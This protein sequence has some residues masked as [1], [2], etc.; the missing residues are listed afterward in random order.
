MV[1]GIDSISVVT[2]E[3][4]ELT[5]PIVFISSFLSVNRHCIGPPI[6]EHCLARCFSSHKRLQPPSGVR[7]IVFGAHM[8]EQG[9][10]FIASALFISC[11]IL[12]ILLSIFSARSSSNLSLYFIP[13][14]YELCFTFLLFFVLIIERSTLCQKMVRLLSLQMWTLPLLLNTSAHAFDL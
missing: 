8:L 12:I 3:L 2:G 4:D 9:V 5:F 11:I 1:G 6:C 10:A 7:L 13:Y 14:V